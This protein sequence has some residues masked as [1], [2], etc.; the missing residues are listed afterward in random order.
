MDGAWTEWRDGFVF[1]AWA[2]AVFTRL[3]T[4][5]TTPLAEGATLDATPIDDGTNPG[6]RSYA[7]PPTCEAQPFPL[8]LRQE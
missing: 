8:P 7:T 5:C 2:R 4:T 1:L 3:S 6:D